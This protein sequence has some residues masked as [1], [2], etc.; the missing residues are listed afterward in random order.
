MTSRF[1]VLRRPCWIQQQRGRRDGGTPDDLASAPGSLIV[2]DGGSAGAK[3]REWDDHYGPAC[4]D[5]EVRYVRR[6]RRSEIGH[7]PHKEDRRQT[8]LERVHTGRELSWT[9]TLG[10]YTGG[11]CA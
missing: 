6:M 3:W 7:L 11:Q 10:R 9:T 5:T 8:S 1:S 2:Q 4:E